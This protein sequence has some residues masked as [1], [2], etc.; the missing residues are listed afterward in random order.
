MPPTAPVLVI[1]A[2]SLD[3]KGHVT[4]PLHPGASN[5]GLVRQSVGGV[6]RNV[7]ENLARLGVSVALMS[8]IGDDAMGQTVLRQAREIGIDTNPSIVV[9][10]RRTGAYLAVLDS[11]GALHV[12]VDDMTV[13]DAITPRYIHDRRKLIAEAAMVV[14]DANL[15]PAALETLFSI[16]H[17]TGVRVC[18]D[19]TSPLL[20][21]RLRPYVPK[22]A[23]TTPNAAEAEALS[24]LS[25]EDEDDAQR[26][27]RYL[28]TVG[29]GLVVVT[30]G[31]QGL[32]YATS[33]ESGRFPAIRTKVVDPTGAGDALTAGVIFGLLNELEPVE[34]VRLGLAAATLTLKCAETVCPDLSLEKL[35][36]Q[37]VV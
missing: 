19:P 24:G 25:I 31:E 22:L 23:L 4:G 16:T 37:L 8:A 36:N 13:L 33:E 5:P 10:G 15:S 6:A 12:A 3:L 34:A 26:V 28:V 9:E 30:L 2:A 17:K 32:A 20:A 29:T 27:A 14:V 1:G 35:Y 18:A 7:A 11:A 21:E